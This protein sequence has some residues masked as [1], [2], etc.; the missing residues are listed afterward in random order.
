MSCS[1]QSSVLVENAERVR[2][3]HRSALSRGLCTSSD[4]SSLTNSICTSLHRPMKLNIQGV[5]W[6][7]Q[8]ATTT[9]GDASI[10]IKKLLHLWPGQV[11]VPEQPHTQNS[12]GTCT[13]NTPALS[14]RPQPK[15]PQYTSYTNSSNLIYLHTYAMLILHCNLFK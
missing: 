11:W 5:E 6:P 13:S 4:C 14:Y 3:S 12:A 15:D 7:K 10:H 9:S 1:P 8:H 2:C